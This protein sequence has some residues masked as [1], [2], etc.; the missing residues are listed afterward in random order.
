M[1]TFFESLR[2]VLTLLLVV[3]AVSV[4]LGGIGLFALARSIR[5]LRIPP[6]ADFFTT[7]RYIPLPLAIVLDLLD[8]GLDIFSAPIM[9]I[10]L[11][12]MGLY[13][14]RNKATIE[15]LIPFTNILP[16]FTVSWFVARLFNLGAQP[17]PYQS[18]DWVDR[19]RALPRRESRV[20]D[21][22]DPRYYRSERND[23]GR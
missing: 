12:R 8:F 11:D 5:R 23:R 22:D 2:G 1:D 4:V 9:W 3:M 16:T 20:I 6:D 21:M 7:M 14:L 15:A 19:R 10:A 18:D 17:W 13:N